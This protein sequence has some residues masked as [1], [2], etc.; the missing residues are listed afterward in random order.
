MARF[1]LMRCN[2]KHYVKLLKYFLYLFFLSLLKCKSHPKNM[3]SSLGRQDSAVRAAREKEPGA[4][5]NMEWPRQNRTFCLDFLFSG[6]HT[7][8]Y[9]IAVCSCCG[10]Q[11]NLVLTETM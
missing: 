9:L 10:M 1:W 6:R 8:T 11:G 4:L 7:V 5:V 2:W 3:S